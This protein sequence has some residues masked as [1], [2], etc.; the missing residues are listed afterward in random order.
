MP[1][2]MV[3][4]HWDE[5]TGV[6]IVATYPEGIN[7]EE[8]TMMQLYSQHEFT[9]EA[10]MV[11]LTAGPINLASYYTGPESSIYVILLLLTSEDPD[12][13]E[14]GMI[15]ISRQI[16]SNIGTP[17]LEQILPTY[18]Q[19]LSV[20]PTLTQEQRYASIINNEI[21]RLIINRL[22]QEV[23][24]PKSE[25]AVW[26]RDVYRDGLVDSEN[27]IASLVK[28]GMVKVV[29][30]KGISSD[31]VFLIE[32]LAIFR[33]P[34]IQL[35]KDPVDRHL[36]ETL[37]D[38]Y[39][40][41]VRHFFTNYI[42][43]EADNLKIIEEIILNP[44]AYEVLKLIREAIVTRNDLEKLR[45]KGVDDVDQVLKI[46]WENKMI[47]VFQDTNGNE[48]YCLTCDFKLEPI[49]PEYLIDTIRK[50]Y[51]EKSQNEQ[52]LL[53][54][55]DTLK[56]QYYIFKKTYETAKKE[57]ASEDISATD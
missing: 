8:K 19:R 37:V 42:P 33:L 43:S 25:L 23:A 7:L 38:M 32:D 13:F 11:S 31:L 5:R 55:L 22:H 18:F 49:Y 26:L 45:K 6:E 36:P 39:R 41:E 56:D 50:Q 28:N 30:V 54:A 51:R 35:L 40:T 46:M 15:E 3:I 20:Y 21:K 10:G 4:M 9:G 44:P 29:S 12:S 27:I 2:G 34:P 24:I 16:L 53:M 52:V 1:S 47:A 57:S 48:Y 17:N 14:E